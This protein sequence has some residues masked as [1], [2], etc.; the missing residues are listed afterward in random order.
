MN[1]MH[2]KAIVAVFITMAAVSSD[3]EDSKQWRVALPLPPLP[4]ESAE[5]ALP[6]YR[7]EINNT[8]AE[9]AKSLESIKIKLTEWKKR[10]N[11]LDAHVAMEPTEISEHEVGLMLPGRPSQREIVNK[12]I[13]AWSTV[14][15][16]FQIESRCGPKDESQD[17]ELYDGKL[18][19][20]KNFVRDKHP[21][22]AQIQW[23]DG[24][25]NILN[26]PGDVPGNVSGERWCS[27][28][29]I[30]DNVFLTAGHCFDALAGGWQT[31]ARLVGGKVK[32]LEPNE[33]ARL[34]HVNFNYQIDGTT[35]N[36][37]PAVVYPILR[38][39]EHKDGSLD[40]A[41]V[42]LGRGQDGKWPSA[43]FLPAK[44]AITEATLQKISQLTVIQHPNGAPKKIAAGKAIRSDAAEVYY[45]DVD[46]QGGSSGS[47]VLDQEGNIIGVHTHG[48]CTYGGGENKGVSTFAIGKVSKT[49]R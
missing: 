49:I 5:A 9:N 22:T 14:L 38:L 20:T 1:Q 47:G 18:G 27:G 23:N 12:N 15:A 2:A 8:K 4:K 29:L 28:T 39:V 11:V 46:T 6:E 36:L 3:A 17:V 30:S 37:R 31:P 21:A 48:G 24:L 16:R 32:P 45:G 34:M 35:R 41:V 44:V 40:Y 25:E 19:P 42:E 26:K 33:L 10:L 7:F 43:H 13:T